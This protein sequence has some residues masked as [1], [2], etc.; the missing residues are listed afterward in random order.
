MWLGLQR[1]LFF[2]LCSLF[3]VCTN[4][5][6]FSCDHSEFFFILFFLLQDYRGCDLLA[7][8]FIFKQ[9]LKKKRKTRFSGSSKQFSN[10]PCYRAFRYCESRW[11]V[12]VCV[13]W[14]QCFAWLLVSSTRAW[15]CGWGPIYQH[16]LRMNV[17][18]ITYAAMY[19]L[20]CYLNST[21]TVHWFLFLCL[22][23]H[24]EC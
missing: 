6:W 21:S 18:S 23:L 12:C 17:C 14:W 9:R 3:C 16:V 7:C 2:I 11:V 13:C 10:L 5:P 8:A 1:L 15:M 24:T 20:V 22:Q 4:I 19:N